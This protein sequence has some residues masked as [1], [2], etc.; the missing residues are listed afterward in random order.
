MKNAAATL[1]GIWEFSLVLRALGKAT[2]ALWHQ[3]LVSQ[4]VAASGEQNQPLCHR[5]LVKELKQQ[6]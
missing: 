2:S 4:K 1:E 5:H 6:P 3:Q